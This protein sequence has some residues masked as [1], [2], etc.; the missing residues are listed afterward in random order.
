MAK[1]FDRRTTHNNSIENIDSTIFQSL[2]ENSL[3]GILYGNPTNGNILDANQSAATMFGYTIE[4][5]RTLNRNDVF[6]YNHSS[7]IN[8]I[9]ERQKQ[10]H[11]KGELIGVRKNGEH[12]PIEFTSSIFTLKNGETRTSTILN[13]ITDRKKS[14]EAVGLLLNNT[15]ESFVLINKL[16]EIVSFNIKFQSTFKLF[17]Q[18]EVQKGASILGFVQKERIHIVEEIY[19]RVLHGEVIDDVIIV[20]SH[21]KAE[22]YFNVRY[23][24][25]HDYRGNIIGAFVT[26]RDI[27]EKRKA[28][29]EKEF[30]QRNKE[31]LI[32]ATSDLIWSVSKDFKLIAANQSFIKTMKIVGNF[33]LK[34]GDNLLFKGDFDPEFIAFWKQMYYRG[35]A[36]ESFNFQTKTPTGY[37]D[38]VY[39]E[40]TINPI[41]EGE[42]I[43]G[44]ACY[45]RDITERKS[46]EKA[47]EKTIDL[48][49]RASR[50]AKIGGWEMNLV[51]NEYSWSA[52]IYHILKVGRDFTPTGDSI[53]NF[54]T[55]E[56]RILFENAIEN[57][58]D[59]GASWNLDLSAYTATGQL[60]DISA[61][62]A[63]VVEN[64]KTTRLLGTLQ[65][66]TEIK[67][68]DK[69]LRESEERYRTMVEFSPDSIVVHANEK[70]LYVNPIAV[71]MFGGQ[72]LN[73]IIGKSI[74]D[75]IHPD[76]H[77]LIQNRI[78]NTISGIKN[79][80]NLDYKLIMLNGETRDIV[81]EGTAIIYNGVPAIHTVMK[82]VTQRKK[83]EN[84]LRLLAS[85]VTH[86]NDSVMITDADSFDEPGPRIVYV[87]AAFTKM[88]GYLPEDVIGRSPRILQGPNTDPA[89]LKRLSDAI[90]KW[91]PCEITV[92]NYKKNGDE[93]WINFSVK[94]V[95]DSTGCY[96]HWISVERDVT[97][98]KNSELEREQIISELSQNNKDLK[99]FSYV[100]SHNLRAPIANLL[101]LTSLIDQY[102][103]PNKSLKQ[104][105][106]GVRQSALMFDDTV[107]DL[108]KVLVI[109][110]QTNIIKV[111]V[112][113]ATV[114]NNVLKQLGVALED[115]TVKI[116][117]KF[118]DA[119]FVLFTP[120]YMESVLLNL[121]TNA[122]KYKS[123]KR[124]LK[125]DIVSNNTDDFVILKFKD[126]GIGIDIEKYKDKVFKL[127]QRFHDNPDGK[128]LGL[129]LVKSQI[130]ALGGS[131]TLES[132]VNKG[133]TFIIKFKK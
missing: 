52:E 67:L 29:A 107:K 13:D 27:T 80:V 94:P 121:F 120:S 99:Q 55:P 44:I 85:V 38:L 65:D 60:I 98:Q 32:N 87:N 74:L 101:G 92:V 20:S 129:Y 70:I 8:S 81:A 79:D 3:S 76:Y 82:D 106:D 125:I 103:I 69:K 130:E 91:K 19:R 84:L 22:N 5:L 11:V 21:N 15:E 88:T 128:G 68:S 17:F 25:A 2:F 43:V 46:L 50:L 124:K 42:K 36:G 59:E 1:S 97:H 122:I 40:T 117:Y 18:A 127:Y 56:S 48:L 95:A 112:N 26:L 24:P 108:S 93:F 35:L 45:S 86:T 118:A 12:F 16:L 34:S 89:E 72:S 54:F 123:L 7:M 41:Y 23:K 10:G 64:S 47:L 110:D 4:E 53:L 131:I 37:P 90:R 62:G 14:E 49:N 66:V 31:A 83:E 119:P 73:D 51:N 100:T 96:T 114:V 9:N 109:K 111:E 33:D 116:N 115:H 63:A 133:T 39:L 75:I 78:Q 71:K 58:I 61:Q 77:K 126:N 113:F 30:E 6:D 102:K 104:I 28:I 132:E 57:S 105:I